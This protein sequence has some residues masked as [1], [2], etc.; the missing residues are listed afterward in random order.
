MVLGY[1]DAAFMNDTGAY[2]RFALRA[3]GDITG[4]ILVPAIVAA[5]LGT[6]LDAHYGTGRIIF[7]VCLLLAFAATAF[8]LVKKVRMYA[9][10]YQQLID[11]PVRDRSAGR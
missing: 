9:K 8:I 10:E 1:T 4:T 3:A 5:L 11:A 2:L 7:V 6:A